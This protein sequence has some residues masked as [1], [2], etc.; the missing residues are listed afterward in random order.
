MANGG[1]VTKDKN[2]SKYK[3]TDPE[4]WINEKGDHP[5]PRTMITVNHVQRGIWKP[6][7]SIISVESVLK[8]L[9]SLAEVK[10]EIPMEDDG[11]DRISVALTCSR[12][13]NF[14]NNSKEEV[15]PFLRLDL[16]IV[17]V[18]APLALFGNIEYEEHKLSKM[19]IEMA[20]KVHIDVEKKYVEIGGLKG[21]YGNMNLVEYTQNNENELSE[22]FFGRWL[23]CQSI[24]FEFSILNF[25]DDNLFTIRGLW[26][27]D[28]WDFI[29]VFTSP[30]FNIMIKE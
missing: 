10:D 1:K 22:V 9:K 3:I 16:P 12:M 15:E 24:I 27:V 28:H 13:L 26:L 6:A 25:N 8:Y 7:D 18:K 14:E 11:S 2:V 29:D 23:E 20:Q 21:L 4:F 5:T 17:S 19:I 30:I